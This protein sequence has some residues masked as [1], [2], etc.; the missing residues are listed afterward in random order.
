MGEGRQGDEETRAERVADQR[1][2]L[3]GEYRDDILPRRF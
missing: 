3:S 1:D 2:L